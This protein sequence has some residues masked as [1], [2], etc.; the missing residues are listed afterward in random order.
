MHHRDL[1]SYYQAI[2]SPSHGQ[3]IKTLLEPTHQLARESNPRDRQAQQALVHALYAT[4][5]Y[6]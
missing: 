6:D 3:I 4:L 2:I 5:N 1:R